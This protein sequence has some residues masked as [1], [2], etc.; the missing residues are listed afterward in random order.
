MPDGDL[1]SVR[2]P[3]TFGRK[4]RIGAPQIR[5]KKSG[6]RIALPPQLV[7]TGV[8]CRK[9]SLSICLT[10]KSATLARE[11]NPVCTEN[12]IRIDWGRESPNVGAQ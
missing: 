1:I 7:S 9:A 4:W 8:L 6:R 5:P 12:P 3:G 10:M 11:M 2:L